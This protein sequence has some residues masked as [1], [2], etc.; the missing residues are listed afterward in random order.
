M[1]KRLFTH[2]RFHA[3]AAV[4][5][6]T[7]SAFAQQAP[8]TTPGKSRIARLEFHKAKVTDALRLISELSN[9]NVVASS[10]AGETE[11][12][13]LLRNIS[14]REAIETL[15]RVSGLW[16]RQDE[17]GGVWRVMTTEQYQKDLVVFRQDLTEVFQLR[18]PNAYAA[19]QA[20]EDLYPDRVELSLGRD[21][22]RFIEDSIFAGQALDGFRGQGVGGNFGTGSEFSRSSLR[23]GRFS[24]SSN[25]FGAGRG[26]R[27]GR[28]R[29]QE[30]ED[31]IK[32]K[33]TADQISRLE[34]ALKKSGQPNQ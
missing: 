31:L 24:R 12:T 5:C 33:L 32:E 11:V 4:V 7:V 18:Y 26:G 19:A 28:G 16:Y 13:M 1:K 23:T 6:W 10:E 15:C 17:A 14:A 34:D 27:I 8:E 22:D 9:L 25:R 2:H 29:S 30:S 21:S 3:A 20:I